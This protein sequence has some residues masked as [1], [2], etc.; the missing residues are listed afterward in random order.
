VTVNAKFE[1]E[2]R[3]QQFILII[4]ILSSLKVN[5]QDA[6]IAVKMGQY[7]LK[8]AKGTE[9]E[10]KIISDS[11]QFELRVWV[12][13]HF[14]TDKVIQFKKDFG[15]KWDYR[16]GYFNQDNNTRKSIVFQD[17][18]KKSIDWGEFEV[19][20]DSFINEKIPS[21]D[22]IELKYIANGNPYKGKI[23]DFYPLDGGIIYVEI[24]DNKTRRV[25]YY[26]EPNSFIEELK[27]EG[28]TTKEHQ[29][30]MKFVKFVLFDQVDYNKLRRIQAMEREDIKSKY[31]R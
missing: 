31:E 14:Y 15:N 2:M 24:Y 13:D 23:S 29:D 3:T 17:S 25:T 4:L 26:V 1:T 30:F 12:S 20:L 28:L 11:I 22:E 27:K 19:K 18:I 9:L 16:L 7:I 5:G 10:R 8:E 21:Q 6:S